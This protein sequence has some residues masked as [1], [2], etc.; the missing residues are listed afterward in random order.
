MSTPKPPTNQDNK[1]PATSPLVDERA[2][3]APRDAVGK[4]GEGGGAGTSSANGAG[5]VARSE[6]AE[7]TISGQQLAEIIA[8][9][10][11]RVSAEVTADLKKEFR[12]DIMLLKADIVKLTAENGELKRRLMER[13][14]EVDSL[15]DQVDHL[16]Q[17][18]RRNSCRVYGYPEAKDGESENTDAIIVKIAEA[19]G[20][21]TFLDQIDRSH[22][23]GRPSIDKPRPIIVK[24]TSYAYKR[25]LMR[26]KSKLKQVDT[27]KA[28]GASKLFIND[29]MTKLRADLAKSVR[30]LVDDKKVEKT[31]YRDGVIFAKINEHTV[32]KVTTPRELNDLL[33][34]VLNR[35]ERVDGVRE[36]DPS[37]T[38]L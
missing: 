19:I 14:E 38:E 17:Y 7:V 16:A 28:F 26:A 34:F 11:A 20:S 1:R 10:S 32:R 35:E 22:R 31:W 13:D 25:R 3:K 5:G 6:L 24:F 15:G 12:K 4:D 33:N 18:S 27:K 37:L 30:S 23:V 21:D 9:V 2:E 36:S 29:D 8:Q